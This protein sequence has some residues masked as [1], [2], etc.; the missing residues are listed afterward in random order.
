VFLG[1]R[2]SSEPSREGFHVVGWGGKAR[3]VNVLAKRGGVFGLFTGGWY[4]RGRQGA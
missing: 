4:L 1:G 3:G 2:G